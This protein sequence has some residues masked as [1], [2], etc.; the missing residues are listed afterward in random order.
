MLKQNMLS[1]S[2]AELRAML[3]DNEQLVSAIEKPLPGQNKPG[4]I[5]TSYMESEKMFLK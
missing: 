1:F 2:V 4:Q 3:K 5:L